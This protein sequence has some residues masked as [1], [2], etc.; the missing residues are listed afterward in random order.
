MAMIATRFH[1]QVLFS[2]YSFIRVPY[3]PRLMKIQS[4]LEIKHNA[5]VYFVCPAIFNFF[6]EFS[7]VLHPN[8]IV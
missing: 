2:D 5:T 4:I 6:R 8:L 7:L 3:D 1:S